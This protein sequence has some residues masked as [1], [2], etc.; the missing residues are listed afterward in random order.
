MTPTEPSVDNSMF[1]SIS[2]YNLDCSQDGDYEL[3]SEV[4]ST[5]TV[6]ETSPQDR[7]IE[8][9]PITTTVEECK[10]TTYVLSKSSTAIEPVDA[11]AFKSPEKIDRQD[12]FEFSIMSS[13]YIENLITTTELFILGLLPS[14]ES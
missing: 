9:E 14:D 2:A 12:K 5:A 11:E 8:F 1:E 13:K 6:I 7:R 10:I 4:T 3:P